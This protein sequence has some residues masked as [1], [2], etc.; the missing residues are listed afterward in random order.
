MNI[1]IDNTVVKVQHQNVADLFHMVSY[2]RR[3]FWIKWRGVLVWKY[4]TDLFN[5][6]ELIQTLLPD[7]LIETGTAEGG[8]ALFYADIMD[9][10]GHGEVITIDPYYKPVYKHPRVTHIGKDSIEAIGELPVGKRTIVSLDASHLKDD[11]L[12]EMYAYAPIVGNGM[13]MVVEDTDM[14]GH[15][16]RWSEGDGPGKQ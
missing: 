15:P 7:Y 10:V 12:R 9:L 4:P 3:A 1:E 2:E 13:Y 6:A 8:A 16:V 11:V 14:S 5:Y